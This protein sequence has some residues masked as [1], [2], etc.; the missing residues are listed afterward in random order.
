MLWSPP[1]TRRLPLVALIMLVALPISTWLSRY[2]F[3]L[4]LTQANPSN[5]MPAD[6]IFL[7]LVLSLVLSITSP[8][9]WWLERSSHSIRRM[10]SSAAALSLTVVGLQCAVAVTLLGAN[11]P[12]QWARQSVNILALTAVGVGLSAALGPGAASGLVLLMYF[13][14]N[15]GIQFWTPLRYI[16]PV[17]ASFE[18]SPHTLAAAVLLA[19]SVLLYLATLGQTWRVSRRQD[20]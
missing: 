6:E 2:A 1:R 5:V 10:A 8:R 11:D 3:S 12:G 4:E 18:E 7:V 17:S 13:L 16:S 9:L 20:G 14:L 15:A 19:A